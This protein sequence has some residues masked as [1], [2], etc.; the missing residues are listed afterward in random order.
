V[1]RAVIYVR[2]S[3]RDQA[4][5]GYSLEAQMGACRQF[6][7]DHGWTLV[8]EY[9]DAGESAKTADRP[10][11]KQMLADIKDDPTV[12]F[13]V[14]HKIDRF[15]RSLEDHVRIRAELKKRGVGLVSAT[16]G[17]EDSPSGRMVEGIL[18]SISAW[19]SEN[20][21][22]ETRKGMLQKVKNGIWPSVA[23][24]G[25]RNVR[26]GEGRKAEAVI[27]P[28]D[29]MAPL[30]R[31]AFELYASGEFPL[32]KL[33]REMVGRGMRTYR[34]AAITRSQLARMLRNRVYI[35]V[36][37]W[38]GLVVAGKHQ[39]L[40]SRET[41]ERVQEVFRVHDKAGARLREH[42]HYLKGT[43]ACAGCG[44]RLS[45]TI[46]KGRYPYFFC[47]GR[48]QR[49]TDCSEAYVPAA[50]LEVQVEDIF[51]K[52]SFTDEMRDRV[53]SSVEREIA[54]QV[55]G[56]AKVAEQ[57]RQ[58][59]S[60]LQI[61]REKLLQAWYATAIPLDLLK[62]EQGRIDG[63]MEAVQQRTTFDLGKLKEAKDLAENAM[64][65]LRNC[66]R[67][68]R[69]AADCEETRRLWSRAFF[70]RVAV[71]GRQ[72]AKVEYA[73]PFRSLL[74]AG[75]FEYSASGSP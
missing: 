18:A 5:G 10:Q 33:H 41:F 57:N 74:G 14:V 53:R 4:E 75:K 69:E 1:K 13:L 17:L 44:S 43:V 25:Y 28:D 21:G 58:R 61:E 34:G 70:K 36:V 64:E 9:I 38:G 16:E 56:S 30:V 52:I 71:S 2:V 50:E 63:E 19:Y 3:S 12:S 7:T 35:G 66:Y 20:L 60:R 45:M 15:A 40:V 42:P 62:K 73:E 29:A 55:A 26:T 23:P 24:I 72:I 68:Y 22:Q 48:A 49:R 51:K 8:G 54:S 39:P 46:S 67:S 32:T 31:Q 27:V 65:L 59:L 11:L 37:V 6:V 47:I